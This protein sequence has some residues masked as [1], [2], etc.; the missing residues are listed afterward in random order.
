MSAGS[1][2]IDD[3]A[4]PGARARRRVLVVQYSQ[5]GQLCDVLRQVAAPL[6][7]PHGIE[8]VVETLVPVEPYP[9]PWPFFRFFDTFPEA[10]YLDPPPIRP[11]SIDATERFDLVILGY[12][13]WFLSP[14]LPVTA[15][16]Q[17][18]E[19]R[20]LLAGTPVVTVVACRDM[21]LM[22]Q[23]EVKK[24]LA[25]CGARLVG[26]VALVDEAGSIGSF[27]ATPMWVLSGKRG[28][29]LGGL[30]PRAGVDRREIEASRRFGERIA[31]VLAAGAP[32]DETLLRGLGAVRVDERLIP[33]ER[34][35]RRGL[36]A[37]GGLL[38]AIGRP[39]APQRQVV[40][41]LYVLWLVLAILLIVPFAMVA[42]RLLAPLMRRRI[43]DQ[44][45]YYGAPSGSR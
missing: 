40:L 33:S 39:G 22:A 41:V 13:V 36:R 38:R 19:A 31:E 29:R 1:R 15:F 10:V 32:L 14:S 27:L 17:S 25:A 45:A 20:A 26:H 21:W 3:A 11:L 34:A 28:P 4:S 16:L 30:I 12:Q 42:K 24:L 6:R 8:L 43:A 7:D 37:W 5:S 35:I 23:E 9:F 2:A 44:K 18:P